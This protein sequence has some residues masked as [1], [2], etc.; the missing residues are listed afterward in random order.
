MFPARVSGARILSCSKRQIAGV[1]AKGS[2]GREQGAA[3]SDET[4]QVSIAGID[5]RAEAG[6]CDDSRR[7]LRFSPVREAR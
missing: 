1:W 5:G 2:G 6:Y 4:V 3:R 7:K